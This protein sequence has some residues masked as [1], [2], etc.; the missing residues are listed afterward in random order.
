[1]NRLKQFFLSEF[2]IATWNQI[3]NHFVPP[4]FSAGNLFEQRSGGLKEHRIRKHHHPPRRKEID[5]STRQLHQVKSNQADI[6]HI[7][8]NTGN[9]DAVSDVNSIATNYEEISSH[10]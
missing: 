8:G 6:D 3:E 10:G 7:A 4:V 2:V 5:A 9:A 1:M